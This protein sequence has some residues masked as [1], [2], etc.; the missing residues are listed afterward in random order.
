[1]GQRLLGLRGT[2]P[3]PVIR[4]GQQL[5]PDHHRVPEGALQGVA[6]ED[7]KLLLAAVVRTA[8]LG[9]RLA[10]PQ[11]TRVHT[12]QHLAVLEGSRAHLQL[13]FQP[14]VVLVAKG[15]QVSGTQRGGLQ[16]VVGVPQVPWVA[17]RPDRERRLT[18]KGLQDL[19]RAIT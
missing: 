19:Q 15:D 13:A 12:Q 10:I 6:S 1:M 2:K 9:S 7:P 17:H 4:N 3:V 16:E 11:L 14:H 8:L 5:A 18:S